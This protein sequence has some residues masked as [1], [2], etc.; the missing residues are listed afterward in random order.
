M[1]AAACALRNPCRLKKAIT[2]RRTRSVSAARSPWVSGLKIGHSRATTRIRSFRQMVCSIWNARRMNVMPAIY[3]RKRKACPI[4]NLISIQIL[5]GGMAANQNSTSATFAFFQIIRYLF[6]RS[7][8]IHRLRKTNK[9]RENFA[10]MSVVEGCVLRL[11]SD[12]SVAVASLCSSRK[13]W[14]VFENISTAKV[15]Q[16]SHRHEKVVA[17]N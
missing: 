7:G 12:E 4:P 9:P 15:R 3:F 17:G 16:Q 1:A 11:K 10:T 8:A 13:A 2:R 6:R 14:G 5:A